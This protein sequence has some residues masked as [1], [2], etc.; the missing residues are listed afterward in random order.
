[1]R[2]VQ[3][4]W[5]VDWDDKNELF[6]IAFS[7][8]S[9]VK[10]NSADDDTTEFK[11]FDRGQN[12]KQSVNVSARPNQPK[13]KFDVLERYGSQCAACSIRNHELLDAAHI[14]NVRDNG[15]DDARNGLILCASHHRAFYA[16]LFAINLETFQIELTK[17]LEVKMEL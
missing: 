13:F 16:E 9:V 2:F 8:Q 5:V 6:L 17:R 7:E 11:P 12:R 4:G 14:I 1:M 15:S 3:L 10:N